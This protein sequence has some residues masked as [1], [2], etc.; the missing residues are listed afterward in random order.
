MQTRPPTIAQLLIAV[1]FALSCFALLLF[2]WIAF[3]GPS[4]LK[5]EGYRLEVPFDEATSLAVE[6]DVRISGVS[7]GK[8][9]GIDLSDEGK[10]VATLEIEAKYAPVPEDTQAILRQKTLLGETYVELTPGSPGNPGESSTEDLGAQGAATDVNA[11]GVGF[12]P[13]GGALDE[14]QVSEAVQLDEI[15]RAFD[16]ETRQA[17]QTWMQEASVAFKGRGDDLNAAIGNL[18]GFANEADELLRVLDS[19]RL[20]TREFVRN[21]GEVFEAL[22]ERK[23]QLQGL[24][25]NTEAVF[26]TTAQRNQDLQEA[27]IA[28]PTFLDESRLTLER[29]EEFSIDTDPLIQQLRPVA[30]ELSP[31]LVD[32]GRLAPELQGFFKGLLPAALASKTG[33]GALQGVLRRDLPAV[34]SELDPWLRQVIPIVQVASDYRREITAFVANTAAATNGSNRP[35][36]NQNQITRYLRTTAPLG[37]EALAAFPNRLKVS[38]TNPYVAPGGYLNLANGLESFETR[39]C[40]SA[41]LTALLDDNSPNDPNFNQRFNGDVAKAQDFYNRL[42]R[43]AFDD[44]NS[45]DNLPAPP[46]AQQGAYTSVGGM[47]P[48]FSQYLHVFAQP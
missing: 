35:G 8:V 9:K 25:R 4:P 15:F 33:L 47:F 12:V 1:V 29:L 21:T 48:E 43:F 30:A 14:A 11:E 13:E 2:L 24:I 46:C 17:F 34:L 6:S 19:Q 42:K 39:H 23:G 44:V 10:A 16:S 22:S 41:G 37:P 40:S 45:S 3:G 36:E 5:P 20:A 38:R 28:L 27:F 7:V 32:L 31:T 18:E 26:S